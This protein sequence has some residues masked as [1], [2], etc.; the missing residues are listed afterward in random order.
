MP[1]R[2]TGRAVTLAVGVE[3]RASGNAAV[4]KNIPSAADQPGLGERSRVVPEFAD[5]R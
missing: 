2:V 1:F 5:A 4:A 3:V